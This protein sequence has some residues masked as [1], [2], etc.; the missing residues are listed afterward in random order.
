MTVGEHVCVPKKTNTDY[1]EVPLRKANILA[2]QIEITY[3]QSGSGLIPYFFQRNIVH[4]MP[5]S[6]T[7][8]VQSIIH[9]KCKECKSCK[10]K[11]VLKLEENCEIM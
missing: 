10:Q 4:A 8:E 11:F 7:L 1:T 5:T 2:Q 6:N 3:P 9:S